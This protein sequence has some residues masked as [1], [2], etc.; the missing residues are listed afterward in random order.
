MERRLWSIK[1]IAAIA[2]P[3]AAQCSRKIPT[4]QVFGD[5]FARPGSSY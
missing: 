4:D 5:E 2:K 3:Q 1:F